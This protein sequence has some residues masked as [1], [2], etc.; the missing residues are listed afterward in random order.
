MSFV[1]YLLPA[2]AASQLAFASDSCGDTT[3][4]TQSDADALDSCTTVSGDIKIKSSFSGTLTLNGV[5]KISGSLTGSNCTALTG[6]I[7][8]SL[9]TITDSFTLSEATLVTELSFSELTTVGEINWEALPALQSLTFPA[10]VTDAGDVIITNTGLTSLDGISLETVGKFQITDNTNLKTININNLK[11]ATDLVNFAGNWNKLEI[12]FPNLAT[13]SNMTFR[14]ISSVSMP[15]LEKLKGQL[16][17]WGTEFKSF[18]AP[19]LTTTADLTFNDNSA[20]TNISM[21]VLKTVKGGFVVSRND[22]LADIDLPELE[23]VTGAI[24][25]S[26]TFDTLSMGALEEVDGGF[27]V[28]STNGTFSCTTFKKM[29]GDGVIRGTYNCKATTPDPTTSNGKSGTSSSS[30]SS[31]TS[32]TSSG[33]AS[34]LA[35][36]ATGIA[37]FFFAFAQFL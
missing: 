29:Q 21:P 24:D 32:A 19:N 10:G 37:A 22:K 9:V 16:G 26:G 25:F 20:L 13:A 1:K 7:A 27:N 3:I 6:I 5:E 23:T 36:P 8:P 12:E 2:L 33:A 14:N 31:G 4:S 28:Q 35:I 15:S 18:S 11:N 30:T 34:S 17:F